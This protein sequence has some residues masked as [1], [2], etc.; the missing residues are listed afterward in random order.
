MKRILILI[1][2][3][4]WV[5]NTSAQQ[6]FCATQQYNE[7]QLLDNPALAKNRS[8]IKIQISKLTT[9]KN[10]PRAFS[11]SLAIPVVVHVIYKTPEQN[12]SDEQII[13]QID[14]LN[15]DFLATNANLA[16]VPE[17]WK[18]IVG[19]LSISFCLVRKDE[20]GNTTTGITRTSTV[21]A[22]FSVGSDMKYD[23]MG[24]HRAWNSAQYL[25][26]WVCNIESGSNAVLGFAQFPGGDPLTDGVVINYKAFGR[27]DGN[28]LTQYNLGRTCTH[29]IGH[30]L[31]LE[32]IWG[33]EDNCLADDDIDD[34]PKQAD[35]SYSCPA[36]PQV[37]CNNTPNGDMF[38]NYMDYTDDRCMMLFT[39]EQVLHMTAVFPVSRDS[40]LLNS[41]TLPVSTPQTD[42]SIDVLAPSGRLCK[43]GIT[44]AV[45]LKNNGQNVINEIK[46]ECFIDDGVATTYTWNGDL[47]AADS[48]IISLPSVKVGDDLH[49]FSARITSANSNSTDDYLLNNFKTQ[50]FL[51][52]PEEYGCPVYPETPEIKIYPVPVEFDLVIE[53]KYKE[54]QQAT[55]SIFNLLGKRIYAK[56]ET[57]STGGIYR[58]NVE[59]LADG[60]YFVQVKTFDKSASAKFIINH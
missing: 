12:I 35:A 20:N 50:S 46:F 23:S 1:M 17:V 38:M 44:P 22:S 15:E 24:G 57:E 39:S 10:H 18:S 28:L 54:A 34:T 6:R 4:L 45:M 14:V 42:A 48:V 59:G 8:E 2:F 33:D 52:S 16:Q 51:T 56:V 5:F 40:I 37:S 11:S 53:T 7:Q 25:N 3:A 19:N 36:F 27:S 55:L 9:D 47:Q 58:V 43:S 13:S 41:N 60:I 31:D 26:I 21:N 32:H 29:E 30:W 49:I